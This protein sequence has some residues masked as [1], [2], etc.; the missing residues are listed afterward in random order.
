RR[1]RYTLRIWP[2]TW[3]A[4]PIN[5]GG[6]LLNE[7]RI[8]RLGT[9][10]AKNTSAGADATPRSTPDRYRSAVETPTG[11]VTHEQKPP[12]GVVQYTPEGKCRAIAFISASRPSR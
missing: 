12:R 2:S 5:S 6:R 10:L 4:S 7:S 9:R 1:A 11:S 8:F 3:V